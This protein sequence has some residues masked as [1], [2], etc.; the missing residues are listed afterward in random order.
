MAEGQGFSEEQQEE[1]RCVM[2]GICPWALLVGCHVGKH[3]GC[4]LYLFFKNFN[5]SFER[6]RVRALTEGEG[7][8]KADSL[9]SWE[10]AVG[11]D[12][13]ILRS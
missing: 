1:S 11:L 4:F 5:N 6:E 8:E 7:E 13:R 3:S 2:W 10:P 9:L 12:P